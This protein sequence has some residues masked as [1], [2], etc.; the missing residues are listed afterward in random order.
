M[1]DS[2]EVTGRVLSL[3]EGD[4]AVR[5]DI[6][7]ETNTACARCR[8]GR[9]CG[10]GLLGSGSGRQVL[11]V[12]VPPGTAISPGDSVRLTM[13]GAALLA[14]AGIA[15]GFPLAGLLTG[16]LLGQAIVGSD[17]GALLASLTGLAAG[18]VLA[19]RRAA[20]LC[21]QQADG[22]GPIRLAVSH[23]S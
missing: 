6:A 12:D 20:R 10:A 4:G 9:G 11:R 21:W 14:A 5:A 16:A 17:L 22:T 15:Y 18:V 19:R 23:A 2:P 7:V 1:V 8:D 13:S 3:V